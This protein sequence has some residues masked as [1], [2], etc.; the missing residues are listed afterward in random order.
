[1]DKRYIQLYSINEDVSK[2][3]VGSLH[4]IADLGYTGVE[5]AGGFYGGLSA[6]DLT[7]ALN[8][9]G[10]EPLG[11]H[12]FSANATEHIDF[13]VKA[14]LKYLI[15]P[16][17]KLETYEDALAF[18]ETLNTVGKKCKENGIIFGYHNHAH[19]FKECK[20]GTLMDT[21]LINTDP[22][23]VCFQLDV[24][25]A[26][27]AGCDVLAFIKKYAGRFKLIHVKECSELTDDNKDDNKWNGPAGKGIID[28]PA[29][30]KASK[31]QGADSFIIER[32]YDYCGDIYK[33]LKE[34]CGFLKNLA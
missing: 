25:W 6:E 19:E 28:W 8:K 5:F 3:F 2:D 13:A 23:N 18:S 16:A 9:V 15:D 10:L 33:C 24:G 20:D 34:D 17:A 30:V 29:V 22:D 1:M 14:G 32:E 27:Y 11:T 31:A 4:R 26:T 12:V 21:L 7:A